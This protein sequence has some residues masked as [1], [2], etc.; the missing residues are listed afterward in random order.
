MTWSGEYNSRWDSQGEGITVQTAPCSPWG[1]T[2]ARNSPWPDSPLSL[3]DFAQSPSYFLH[4]IRCCQLHSDE[5]SLSALSPLTWIICYTFNSSSQILSN[6]KTRELSLKRR[7]TVWSCGSLSM[8][9]EKLQLYLPRSE[10]KKPMTSSYFQI[11]WSFTYARINSSL[12][13]HTLCRFLPGIKTSITKFITIYFV[14]Y[15]I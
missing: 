12:F 9:H 8:I 2:P 6:L 4:T 3:F 10:V 11:T 5:T 15:E 13:T 7:Q 1:T 14:I